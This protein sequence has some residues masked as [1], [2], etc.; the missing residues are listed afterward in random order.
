MT[1]Y[2]PCTL[3][4]SP[5]W[6]ANKSKRLRNRIHP[7]SIKNT[8]WHSRWHR[9]N[10]C[11]N[12]GARHH[13]S[14]DIRRQVPTKICHS[15][16]KSTRSNDRS[17]TL[18]HK[19]YPLRSKSAANSYYNWNDNAFSSRGVPRN[20]AKLPLNL[21]MD[22]R[23]PPITWNTFPCTC[24]NASDAHFNASKEPLSPWQLKV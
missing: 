13:E 19:Y 24:S 21:T 8:D 23:M 11:V 17:R 12:Q 9:H 5:I 6:S 2:T 7:G 1:N 14:T 10:K 18:D 22:G 20:P 16:P 3:L 4:I 15:L